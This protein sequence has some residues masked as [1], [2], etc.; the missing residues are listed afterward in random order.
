VA[1]SGIYISMCKTGVFSGG[2]SPLYY[3][4]LQP[5]LASLLPVK[6]EVSFL[7]CTAVN[8]TICLILLYRYL[9]ELGIES[10]QAAIGVIINSVLKTYQEQLYI[11]IPPISE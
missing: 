1:D 7:I 8:I 9:K 10:K 6:P 3:R 2:D 4:V 5:L 11:S